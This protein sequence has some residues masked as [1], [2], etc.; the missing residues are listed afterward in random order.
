M[1]KKKRAKAQKKKA[2]TRKKKAKAPRKRKAKATT[3]RK[4]AVRKSLPERLYPYFGEWG[5]RILDGIY[6]DSSTRVV[7]NNDDTIDLEISVNIPRGVS[8][9]DAVTEAEFAVGASQWNTP[10]YVS[11]AFDRSWITVGVRLDPEGVERVAKKRFNEYNRFRGMTDIS[12]HPAHMVRRGDVFERLRTDVVGGLK[13]HRHNK[14][15][16]VV[17]RIFWSPDR[18]ER[19]DRKGS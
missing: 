4:P 1:A 10:Q 14:P 15:K 17:V 9:D 7:L 13:R 8:A 5:E 16:E 12:I 18:K 19:P 11:K 3:K 6:Y 2:P